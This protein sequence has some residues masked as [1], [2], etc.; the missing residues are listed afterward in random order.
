MLLHRRSLVG[1]R[2]RRALGAL[3]AV[4]ARPVSRCAAG[5]GRPG[6]GDAGARPAAATRCA[7]ST[8]SAR[9]GRASSTSRCTTCGTPPRRCAA[10]P[11]RCPPRCASRRCAAA[12]A[13]CTCAARSSWPGWS[14]AATSPSRSS[15]T[16][17]R[18]GP[19]SWCGW[20]AARAWWSTPRCRSTPSSTPPATDDDDEHAR[21]T[22]ARHARQL[23][24]HVD[25]LSAP[26]ATGARSPETPGVRRAVRAGRVVPGRGAGGRP[27][28]A[29]VRRGAAGRAGDPDH[30]DRAAAHGRPRLEPRG[31]GRPGPRDP[32]ARPRAARAAGAAWAA[33]STSS[34]ARS[35]RPSGTTT[36]PSARW[37]RG[38]WSAPGSSPSSASPTTSCRHRARSRHRRSVGTRVAPSCT[39]PTAAGRR[40]APTST[41]DAGVGGASTGVPDPTREP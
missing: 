22:C 24:T 19:T 9:P 17:A 28:P 40:A 7:T 34:A 20:P 31:A 25:Q 18:C 27:R 35:T 6:R 13:S 15:S 41:G 2:P 33:T 16:T 32:P 11:S 37:S 21:A 8:T 14:T 5:H 36:R 30:P 12:G 26:S 3:A 39:P 38:C 29:R 1:A 23:R 10:R 4:A